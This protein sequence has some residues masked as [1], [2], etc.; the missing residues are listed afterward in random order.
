MKQGLVIG[1]T[2]MLLVLIAMGAW[3]VARLQADMEFLASRVDTNSEAPT[4]TQ[5]AGAAGDPGLARDVSE[6][7]EAV[8]ALSK[9]FGQLSERVE[10]LAEQI[11]EPTAR[12]EV[13]PDDAQ[14]D[15]VRQRPTQQ[16][17]IDMLEGALN[18]AGDYDQIWANDTTVKIEELVRNAP[19]YQVADATSARCGGTLCKVE[20]VLP[21]D[22]DRRQRG[23]FEVKLPMDL[24]SEL[25]RA[26]IVKDKE[27]D[28]SMR[29]TF[30]MAREGYRLPTEGGG[31][32]PSESESDER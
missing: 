7:N 18:D 27:P 24:A 28:G 9:R 2:L 20:A 15:V 13:A 25:P 21:P 5:R 8:A 29:Y 32:M 16:E 26:V 1:F 11:E 12:E 23:L 17:R 22:T 10:G 31:K 6:V 30:Y 14:A 4:E 19:A 3:Q